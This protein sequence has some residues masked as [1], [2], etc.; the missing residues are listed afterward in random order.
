[1]TDSTLFEIGSVSKTFTATL[2]SYAQVRGRLSL[3]DPAS[4]YFTQLRGSSLD[5]VSLLNLGTHTTGGMPLQVPDSVKTEDQLLTYFHN[6]TPAAAPGTVRTYANPSVGLF[7]MIAAKSLDGDFDTLMDG[8]VIQPLGLRHTYLRVPAAQMKDY[9]QGYTKADVPAR[10]TPAVIASEAYGIRTTADD[11]LRFTQANMRMLQI[12]DEL[13]RAITATHTGY[14]RVGAM[15]QD[16][17]W[18]QYHYPVGLHDLVAGNSNK[19]ALAPN[20]AVAIAPPLSPR[21]DVLI[22][23]TGSTS[24]FGAYV[25]F[26]PGRKVGIVLLANRNYPNEARVTAAHAIL[27]RLTEMRR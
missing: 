21:E 6:W 9:A 16:L 22:N 17:I 10:M 24:G 26:V 8:D 11:L 7:G 5:T 12:D 3:S 20:P 18:E 1:V 23:K 14:Y 27:T 13:Q 15:M 4:K 19:V 2:A 25:A